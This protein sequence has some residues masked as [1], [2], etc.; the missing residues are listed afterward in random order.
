MAD[1]HDTLSAPLPVP[2]PTS[3][4][5]WEGLQADEVRL[6][7]CDECSA[8]VYYPRSHCPRC[9]CP[10]LSWHPVSGRGRLHTFTVARQATS[11]HFH[12]EVP[13]LLAVV[14]LDEGPR[15]TTTLVG[16]EP[17][18]ISIGMGVEPVFDHVDADHT[19][20]RYRPA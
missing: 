18:Q 14:E 12:G 20:L 10:R 15:L 19:L 3:A 16:V 2:T 1:E 11:P 8:W 9:L 6:Q 7:R 13:Q 17:A 4:P 5:F